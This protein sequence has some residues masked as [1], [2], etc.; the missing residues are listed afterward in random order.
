MGILLNPYISFPPA[1]G[2]DA[3]ITLTDDVAANTGNLTEYTFSAADMGGDDTADF[4]AVAVHTRQNLATALG[5]PVSV[6]GNSATL[7]QQQHGSDGNQRA[8]STIAIIAAPATSTADVVVSSSG[9]MTSCKIE[10]YRITGIDGAPESDSGFAIIDAGAS[11]TMSDTI[12]IPNGGVALAASTAHLNFTNTWT[13][14][15]ERVDVQVESGATAV[16]ASSASD[17]YETGGATA[18]QTVLSST[19]ECASMVCAVWAPA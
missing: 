12:T 19:P 7:V 3:T 9:Q 2:G 18:I 5:Q 15:T 10:V 13:N 14:I 16:Q 6:G 11:D 4:I 8:W 17:V 1:A